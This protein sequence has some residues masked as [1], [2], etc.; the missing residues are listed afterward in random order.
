MGHA[1]Q[2]FFNRPEMSMDPLSEVLSLMK[3]RTYGCGGFDVGGD[4]CIDFSAYDGIKYYALV[5]GEGWLSVEGELEPLRLSAGDC[6]LLLQGR[7]F[8]LASDL[9]LPAVELEALPLP[10]QGGIAIINGGGDSLMITGHFSLRGRHSNILLEAMPAVVHLNSEIDK[11]ALRWSIERLMLELQDPQPGANLVAEH[12]A[13]LILLQAIRLHLNDGAQRNVGWLLALADKRLGA[14]IG[15]MHQ[16]PAYRWTV[17]ELAR[18]AGM[19]RSTFAEKFKVTVGQSPMEYLTRWRMVLAA[20]R[21]INSRDPAS[22]ISLCLGYQSEG[23][24]STAFKRIMGRS[25]RA[26][27]ASIKAQN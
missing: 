5:R 9:A 4:L 6:F 24:F 20:E 17:S 27:R 1:P 15:A 14:A 12:L 26:Y 21:L 18:S 2:N 19:S 13:H 23:A 7:P 11:A 22:S 3:L 10:R 8:R 16:E 25:P